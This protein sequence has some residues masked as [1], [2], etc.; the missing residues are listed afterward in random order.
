PASNVPP[1]APAVSTVIH[2]FTPTRVGVVVTDA[3]G[4]PPAPRRRTVNVIG[5]GATHATH[6]LTDVRVSRRNTGPH[7]MPGRD[8]TSSGT[9][10]SGT[11]LPSRD[12]TTLT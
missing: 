8:P 9:E 2:R 7:T 11:N 3:A 5:L 12:T 4:G 6:T 10:S 1:G